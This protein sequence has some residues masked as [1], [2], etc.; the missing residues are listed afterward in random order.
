M[1]RYYSKNTS[2][3]PG[4]GIGMGHYYSKNTTSFVSGAGIWMHLYHSKNTKSFVPGAGIWIHTYYS[5]NNV[6]CSSSRDWLHPN[7]SKDTTSFF[8]EQGFGQAIIIPRT[9]SRLFLEQGLGGTRG[10]GHVE[11]VLSRVQPLAT[12]WQIGHTRFKSFW[13]H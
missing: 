5:K 3:V 2:F 13:R 12:S 8:L 9:Q 6:I 1:G 10:R 11:R 7:Y 4:A